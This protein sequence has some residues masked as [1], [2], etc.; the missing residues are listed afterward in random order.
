[1]NVYDMPTDLLNEE[2]E[3]L[4]EPFLK[5]AE[6]VLVDLNIHRHH[7]NIDIEILADKPT[8]GITLQECARLNRL[9]RDSIEAQNLITENYTLEVSSP[10]LDRPL[11]TAG[12]FLRVLGRKI[13]V[14]LLESIQN[15]IEY[16][17]VVTKVEGQDLT[18]DIGR[19][20]ILI[21]I[22]SINKANHIFH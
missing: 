18:I 17:G 5:Q 3:K 21:P 12:D 1:M 10:G 15:R 20:E 14:F 2:L 11:K 16:E 9:M 13:Q 7:G 4:M 19:G 22:Q 8:G 6:A